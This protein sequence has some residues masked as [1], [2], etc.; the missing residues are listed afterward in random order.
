[1]L[2]RA[3]S[4]SNVQHMR[5]CRLSRLHEGLLK[6]GSQALLVSRAAQGK[7][8]GCAQVQAPAVAFLLG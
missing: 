3:S 5:L 1:M 2:L 7:C 4:R 6:G 8:A